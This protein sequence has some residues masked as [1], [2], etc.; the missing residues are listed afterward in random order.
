MGIFYGILSITI[1]G[2]R[3]GIEDFITGFGAGEVMM[4]IYQVIFKKKIANQSYTFPIVR[5][6]FSAV[7]LIAIDALIRY[8]GFTSFASFTLI[9]SLAT[10]C[11]WITRKDLIIPSLLSGVL[12]TLCILPLYYVTL[13]LVP[14][15]VLATYDFAHLPTATLV[16]GI[17]LVELIFWLIAGSFIGILPAFTWSGKF[18]AYK[19]TI[20]ASVRTSTDTD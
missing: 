19:N 6:L 4:V 13:L 17:P 3:V 1:T 15:W 9:T 10:L 18:V 11:M 20:E 5:L 8:A 12:T 14:G 7:V 2:T 16:T